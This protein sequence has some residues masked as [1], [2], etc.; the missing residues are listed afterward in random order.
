MFCVAVVKNLM[1]EQRFEILILFYLKNKTKLNESL[2]I[3]I[4]ADSSLKADSLDG[5]VQMS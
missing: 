1:E 4:M 5:V 3:L 2:L